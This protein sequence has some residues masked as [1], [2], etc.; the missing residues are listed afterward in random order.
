MRCC[1]LIALLLAF[2]PFL[3]AQDLYQ[4]N[5][6]IDVKITF[7]ESNWDSLLNVN[8]QEGIDDRRL[9]GDVTINGV[10]YPQSGIRY[11]GSSSYFNVYKAGSTKLPFNVK[12]DH[13]NKKQ[14]LPGGYTTLKLSNVFRDP[15]FLR[16]VMAY[17]IAR[18]YMP[19]PRANFARVYVNGQYVGLYNC[20]ESV[21]EKFLTTFYGSDN[22]PLI[23]CDPDYTGKK[24]E[25]CPSTD[26]ASLVYI[27]EDSLC[28]MNL[29]E[30]EKGTYWKDLI[31]FIRVLNKSPEKLDSIFDVD[32]ALWMLAFDNVLVN[33][34]SYIGRLCHN[35]YLYKDKSGV[36]HPIVWDMNMCF[37]G[38][39]YAD[40]GPAL[41]TDKMATLSPL[42]HIDNER[43]PMIK[44]VLSNPL[45]RKI[46]LAHLRTIVTENF[47]NGA[48]LKRGE[49]IQKLISP[50]VEK[51]ANRLY[52]VETFTKNLHESV[53]ADNVM[54]VGMEELMSKRA[55]YLLSHPL[56]VDPGPEV[57]EAVHKIVGK[58][59]SI[60]VKATGAQNVWLFY[61]NGKFDRFEKV[62]MESNDELVARDGSGKAP[63]VVWKAQV[64]NAKSLQYYIVAEGEKI[65][66]LSP[67]RAAKEFY[68]I[69]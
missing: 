29:Y 33:L 49:E 35:Y 17:E 11:K 57:A 19:A 9:V 61:R 47:S 34:D 6:I 66:T 8:K 26:K 32:Q 64:D 39:R 21:D 22:G 37:G 20:T 31:A 4:L 63:T 13:I 18:K 48:Y 38:F 42:L 65:A 10:K 12:V 58:G 56:L 59:A 40:E 16:E 46:Y 41:S 7:K 24:I 68:Q 62:A 53:K 52:P 51:D 1:Y 55:D 14:A 28:Y 69:K 30:L 44:K 15:S 43:R 36:F 50:Q 5:S 60:S 2:C 54:I 67:A 3:H 23:K 25:G 45:Y 27:G